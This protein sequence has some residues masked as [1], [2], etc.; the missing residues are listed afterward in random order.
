MRRVFKGSVAT[1]TGDIDRLSCTQWGKKW[2]YRSMCRT[3]AHLDIGAIV[4]VP[5]HP[6]FRRNHQIEVV[7]HRGKRFRGDRWPQA[8][9][10]HGPLPDQKSFQVIESL[11]PES[12]DLAHGKGSL[13]VDFAEPK[14]RLHVK[15]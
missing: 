8:L 13:G 11:K 15:R 1:F 6:Q 9:D 5:P 12:W 7:L 10:H 14:R 3:L 4:P 2:T